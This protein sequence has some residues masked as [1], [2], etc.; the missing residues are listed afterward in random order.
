MKKI[1]QTILDLKHGNCM[2]ACVASLFELPLNEI[3]NFMKDGGDRYDY[4]LQ[5]WCKKKNL[6]CLDVSIE[7]EHLLKY[8]KDI[9]LIG[10]GISPR[11]SNNNHAVII[12]NGKIIH[13]PHPSNKGLMGKP[14]RYSIFIVR[15]L[16]S[17]NME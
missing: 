11:D 5:K 12:K 10:V 3:P 8:F 15:N 7:D 9:Y 6:L 17:I 2:Q 13:D 4:H 1:K 16:R 14:T